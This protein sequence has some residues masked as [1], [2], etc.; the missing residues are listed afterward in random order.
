MNRAA[1]AFVSIA[2]LCLPDPRLA[3]NYPN[4][5]F[6][7]EFLREDGVYMPKL[8]ELLPFAYDFPIVIIGYDLGFRESR[9][10]DLAQR[11]IDPFTLCTF[12]F[13]WR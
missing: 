3:R 9:E 8:P 11:D 5:L 6:V 10:V 12:E 7:R 2:A 1:V 13:C 4:S